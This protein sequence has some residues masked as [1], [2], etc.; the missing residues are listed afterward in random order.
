VAQRVRIGTDPVTVGRGYGCTVQVD[1]P[2]MAA[3]H[4]RLTLH[5]NGTWRV[6]DLGSLSGLRRV[7]HAEDRT[8]TAQSQPFELPAGAWVETGRTR[9]RLVRS[10]TP[11][12]AERPLHWHQQ[13]P[14]A[15]CL[16]LALIAILAVAAEAWFEAVGEFKPLSLVGPTLASM[17]LLV[18]W[19]SLWALAGRLTQGPALMTQH[20][21]WA[22]LMLL[23]HQC[24]GWLLG[25]MA[26]ALDWPILATAQRPVWIALAALLV[27]GHITLAFGT[28]GRRAAW[29]L[30]LFCTGTLALSLTEAWQSHRQLLPESFMSVIRPTGWRLAEGEG[31][32]QLMTKATAD[33]ARIDALRTVDS[34][35]E[36]LD[37]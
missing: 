12:P 13:V 6:E 34:D 16:A 25:T 3:E 5:D 26:F 18:G 22:S 24:L 21:G 15:A 29:T 28:T 17:A 32:D 4:A 9:W 11:V 30:G 27:L 35:E 31:L 23:G 36:G 8:G 20:L 10:D 14:V 33:K 19:S 1:D 7:A 2:H 37:D